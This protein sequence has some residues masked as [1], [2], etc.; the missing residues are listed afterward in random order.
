MNMRPLHHR[1]IFP[2]LVCTAAYC[3]EGCSS[4]GK[5]EAESGSVGG[6]TS[7][8]H[9]IGKGGQTA[10]ATINAQGEGGAT[11]NTTLLVDGR[12]V[13]DADGGINSDAGLNTDLCPTSKIVPTGCLGAMNEGE[14]KRCNGLDDDCDGEVDEGCTCT[15]GAV[16][17]CFKGPPGR[18]GV[19][20]CSDGFQNCEGV[21]EIDGTWGKCQ[22][23]IAPSTE[24]CDGL[25][26]D[27]NG[28]V[29]EIIACVPVG[30]CPGPN[31]PRIAVGRPFTEYPLQGERFY[32][33]VAKSWSWHIEGGPCDKLGVGQ[34]SFE[35]TNASS[36][37]AA[38]TPKL[39]GDYTVT[40]TVI[41]EDGG[42]FT[43][44]WVVHVRGP[45][46][47]SKCVIRNVRRRTSIYF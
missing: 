18:R 3:L 8:S 6:A 20:G 17:P 14:S 25:D 26:N 22:Q 41:T 1:S 16:Q 32:D 24:I 40:L 37:D 35:L 2:I 36:R 39:S 11:T 23:G 15:L 33:G 21:G 9:G 47:A 34:P 29:D 45:D 13:Y 43:C 38:F 10:I 28:C 5:V 19:G 12:G 44:T 7:T 46:Y 4:H 42:T 31:D 27:C 30:E